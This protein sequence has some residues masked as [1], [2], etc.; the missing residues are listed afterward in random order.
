ML[1]SNARTHTGDELLS[2]HLRSS[3]APGRIAP[4][5]F[6]LNNGSAHSHAPPLE[7]SSVCTIVLDR[8]GLRVL[9]LHRVW[10]FN[11]P[12]QLPWKVDGR[13]KLVPRRRTTA[14]PAAKIASPGPA[15]GDR[16]P[17]RSASRPKSGTS[18]PVGGKSRRSLTARPGEPLP[19]SDTF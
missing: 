6:K 18:T 12:R 15:G 5:N 16:A 4:P 1:K 10:V 8:W 9:P 17:A 11:M 13:S 7:R 19:Q 2:H 14:S 3:L